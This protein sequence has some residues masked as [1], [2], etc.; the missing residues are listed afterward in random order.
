MRA[1][2]SIS[3]LLDLIQGSNGS[4]CKR[5]YQDHQKLF[6][7]V[8]GSRHNH[9]AWPGGYQDHVQEAMNIALLL[10][11]SFSS[12]RPLPFTISDLLLIVFLHDIEKPWKYV[13]EGGM[14]EYREG[15][16]TKEDHKR[17]RD[18]KL[19]EYGIVLTMEQQNALEFA[20]GELHGYSKQ[21]RA[22]NEL[23]AMVHMCDIASARLWH[24]H[25]LPKNDPWE[26]AVRNQSGK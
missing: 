26:G 5:L 13:Y 17:F 12:L 11:D 21:H 8:A 22:M 15:M 7:T 19:R 20:E 10:W 3:E 18:Q 23:A 2:L 4:A 14:L 9:Q 1:Y 16:E 25:P 6:I 24:N